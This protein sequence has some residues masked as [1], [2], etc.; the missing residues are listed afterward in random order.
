MHLPQELPRWLYTG[1]GILI[2][3]IYLSGY[4]VAG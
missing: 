2:T 3:A 1:I 4:A